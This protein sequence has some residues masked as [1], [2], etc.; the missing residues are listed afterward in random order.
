MLEALTL[1]VMLAQ[2]PALPKNPRGVVFFC[3]DHDR[4][5]GHELDIIDRETG[6]VIRTLDL[7]DPP[8]NA[9]G[10]VE[11]EVNMQ[12]QEFGTYAFRVRAKAGRF[13]S[14]DSEAWA[15]D[16][17]PGRPIFK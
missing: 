16:R 14:E 9:D 8:R 2:E 4:D 3:P 17:A 13:I 7:G 10:D 15:W 1:V 12:S 11:A 5:D 6:L